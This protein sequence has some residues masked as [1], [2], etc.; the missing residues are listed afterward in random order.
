[1]LQGYHGDTSAMFFAGQPTDRARWLCDIN[2]EAM[3]EG[4]KQCGPGV[5]VSAIGKVKSPLP[6]F[7]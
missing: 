5:P 6:F 7:V 2:R 4:I 3:H 1:M